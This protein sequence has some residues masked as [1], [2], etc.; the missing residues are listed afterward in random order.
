MERSELASP[1]LFPLRFSDDGLFVQLVRLDEAAYRQASFLDERL[2]QSG[3]PAQWR[4]WPDLA[5][6]ATGLQPRADFIFHQGHV[7]S[8]LLSRL[9][10]EHPAIF[11]LREPALLRELA[12][13]RWGERASVLAALLS[14]TWSPQQTAL[15]KA[16]SFVSAIGG[17]LLQETGGRA[18]LLT[19][20]PPAYMKTLLA[21]AGSRS[22]AQAMV[23]AR[24][25]RL[26]RRLGAPVAADSLGERLALGWLAEAVALSDIQ[27]SR[28]AAC[29]WLD[30]DRLLACPE[31]V[32]GA[33]LA[34]LAAPADALDLQALVRGP[35]LRRY[36]KAPEHAYD[37]ALRQTLLE[38]A[39]RLHAP[40]LHAGMAW[41]QRMA[42]A[43]P[44][45]RPALMRAA[46]A[47]RGPLG[48]PRSAH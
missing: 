18:L 22:E 20:T 30:F 21:G 28:P 13:G 10:G 29:L 37:A 45:V 3:P 43:H 23:Q 14:R 9:L 12:R 32:L 44:E 33:A 8:T 5:A 26:S 6:A 48:G 16:T 15:I 36:A 35:I 46:A 19:A 34:H 31:A 11:G 7:G 4:A 27:D 24:V 47:A 17:E 25:G 41:L 42:D 1:A 38:D 2:L 39:A 40:E